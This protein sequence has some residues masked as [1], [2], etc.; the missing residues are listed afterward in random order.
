MARRLLLLT[1]ACGV[2]AL[3]VVGLMVF[4]PWFD[5]NHQS[6]ESVVLHAGIPAG[7]TPGPT[8]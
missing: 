6:A 8:R 3:V 2:L 1:A 4:R 7:V 5:P